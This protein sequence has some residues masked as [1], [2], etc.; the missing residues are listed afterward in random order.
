MEPLTID[1]AMQVADDL[2][3]DDVV[4]LEATMGRGFDRLRWAS[5]LV[6]IDGAEQWS[7]SVDGV[8]TALCGFVPN[9]P[10]ACNCWYVSTLDTRDVQLRSRIHL[11]CMRILQSWRQRSVVRFWAIADP[12]NVAGTSWLHRLGFRSEGLHRRAG[13]QG[14][15]LTTMAWVE[16]M[17]APWESR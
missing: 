17:P 14:E 6:A 4:E 5:D 15:D 10:G 9:T 1:A 3:P 12:R 8:A 11:D 13:I 2:R 7:W 16:G